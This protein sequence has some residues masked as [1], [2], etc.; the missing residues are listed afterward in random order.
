MLGYISMNGTPG[1]ADQLL[2]TLAEALDQRG[3]RLAGAVQVN[4]DLGPD[5]NCDM[6]LRVL[7][8][9]GPSVRISQ[10]LGTGSEGCRLD[11]GALEMAVARVQKVLEQ[12]VDL[13]IL[14]KFAKQEAFGRGF[15]EVIAAALEQG[16]PILTYVPEDYVPAFSEFAG[17][18]AQAV[19][20]E[21]AQDWCLDAIRLT[22]A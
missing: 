3:I 12:G 11:A 17:D 10:S 16:V 15:R 19:S 5:C 6:D 14:N 22:A 1:E 20:H 21:T 13:V 4:I 2:T 8:D 9:D 18:F 7:G